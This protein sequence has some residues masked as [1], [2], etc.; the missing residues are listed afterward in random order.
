LSSTGTSFI[1][2]GKLVSEHLMRRGFSR[3]FTRIVH[4]SGQAASARKAAIVG[5]EDSFEAFKDSVSLDDLIAEAKDVL[6]E[7]GVP[8][9]IRNEALARL[10][11][12]QFSVSR[13]Q[14]I[15]NYK[16]AF[17]RLRAAAA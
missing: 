5:R 15:F 7:A 6:L 2:V 8:V 1:A 10:T 14:L 16:T 9:K 4:Y 3:P 12:S 11:K 13:R 17:E